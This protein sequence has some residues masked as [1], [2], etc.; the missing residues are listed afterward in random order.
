MINRLE[1]LLE[2]ALDAKASDV[3]FTIKDEEMTIELRVNDKMKSIPTKKED[4]RLLRYLQY[5]A[6]L[7]IGD[8]IKPQTGSFH[9]FVND[10]HLSLRFALIKS[11]YITSGVL[12]ILNRNLKLNIDHLI[13]FKEQKI[14]MKKMMNSRSGLIIFSGP[15]GSGKTTTLYTLLNGICHKKI[16]TIEDPIEIYTH[17]FVQLQVNE[18]INFTYDVGIKQVLRHDPDIIMI[19]E[20]RDE[21]AANMAIRCALTGHLVVTSLH[22]SSCS[23]AIQRMLELNVNPTQLKDVLIGITNQRLYSGIDATKKIN[24]YEI[25]ERKDIEYYFENQKLP[26]EYKNLQYYIQKSI[27]QKYI[28]VKKAKQDLS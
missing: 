19:G 17:K 4:S 12:R 24:V 25:M 11:L 27:H 14:Q 15:T 5:R 21:V 18:G 13:K 3:H 16:Y 8:N 28:S 26:D 22:A 9:M 10:H 1:E 20:I 6:N 23:S 7:D 2:L